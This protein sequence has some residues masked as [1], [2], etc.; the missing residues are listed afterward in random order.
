MIMMKQHFTLQDIEKITGIQS[1]TLRMWKK[2]YGILQPRKIHAKKLYYGVEELKYL[3]NVKVL[4]DAG[5]RISRV[6]DMNERDMHERVRSITLAR[7]DSHSLQLTNE[8]LTAAINLDEFHL[9]NAYFRSVE[10]MGFKHAMERIFLPLMIQIND[11]WITDAIHA[12]QE[13]FYRNFLRQKLMSATDLLP[14]IDDPA[15]VLMF[16]PELELHDV[17]LL[18]LNYLFRDAQYKTIYLGQSVPY[19]DLRMI[20]ETREI[21]T[22]VLSVSYIGNL[23]LHT[24]MLPEIVRTY[25]QVTFIIRV[26]ETC[27][28]ELERMI[29]ENELNN[30]KLPVRME[31][32]GEEIIPDLLQS[33]P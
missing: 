9:E 15:R 30:I 23:N 27:R 17:A 11:L 32:I 25:P 3:L 19:S 1:A 14:R 33:S 12:L 28:N 22:A 5:Y 18:F 16:L 13:H 26:S 31:E 10:R 4:K 24:E 20:L 2:R 7:S 6:L 29:R 21:T 8:M